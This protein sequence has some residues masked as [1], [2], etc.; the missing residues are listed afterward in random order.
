MKKIDVEIKSFWYSNVLFQHLSCYG[1]MSTNPVLSPKPIGREIHLPFYPGCRYAAIPD[2]SLNDGA[3]VEIHSA[4][5]ASLV[6][7]DHSFHL[8]DLKV[9]L[10]W[11]SEIFNHF[12]FR[13]LKII[14]LIQWER[15]WLRADSMKTRLRLLYPPRLKS[16]L[17]LMN[18]RKKKVGR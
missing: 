11:L 13:Y 4:R 2:P 6:Y 14:S 9:I 3:Y 12:L 10:Y 18:Q 17:Y 1:L 7:H 16:Q 8:F 15:W 5:P